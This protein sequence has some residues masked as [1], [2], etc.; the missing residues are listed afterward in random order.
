M[1]SAA[2]LYIPMLGTR[3]AVGVLGVRPAAPRRLLAPE[4]LHLLETFANQT[5]LGIE[6]ATLAGEAQQAQVQVATEL[7]FA[8][9]P[10][11]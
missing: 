1:P 4:Q 9:Q 5:A 3:G 7:A 10:A 2:A 6:R 8:L 11:Y